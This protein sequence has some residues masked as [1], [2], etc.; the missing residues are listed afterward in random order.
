MAAMKPL[1]HSNTAQMWLI[2][3]A[4]LHEE[5]SSYQ[6]KRVLS[7]ILSQKY[8]AS[9]YLHASQIF[10]RPVPFYGH[11]SPQKWNTQPPQLEAETRKYNIINGGITV[12]TL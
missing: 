5:V 1:A 4:D 7:Q 9:L 2:F 6:T 10:G 3:I 12:K 11:M 8:R